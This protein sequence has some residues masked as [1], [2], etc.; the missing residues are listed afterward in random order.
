[1]TDKP[2]NPLAE[3]GDDYPDKHVLKSTLQNLAIAFGATPKSETFM[4]SMLVDGHECRF[5]PPRLYISRRA[6]DVL[7]RDPMLR[8]YIDVQD[9]D[10]VAFDPERRTDPER[11]KLIAG[12]ISAINDG[13]GLSEIIEKF[14]NKAA[15]A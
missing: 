1:M 4:T 7:N 6:A 13:A 3:R 15:S 8:Q 5:N 14:K 2:A 9:G 12:E 10:A 11:R